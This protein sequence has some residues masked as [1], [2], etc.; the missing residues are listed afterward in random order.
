MAS[1]RP[2][3]AKKSAGSC[4]Q[5][6]RRRGVE[7]RANI[8]ATVKKAVHAR[9]R[10]H[11][12]AKRP[13]GLVLAIPRQSQKSACRDSLDGSLTVPFERNSTLWGIVLDGHGH[14]RIEEQ[15]NTCPGRSKM[16]P[17]SVTM[18]RRPTGVIC[19]AMF[20]GLWTLCTTSRC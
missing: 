9:G 20:G 13:R 16:T 2:L 18:P 7:P 17:I 4:A 19:C 14:M 1:E 11:E 6:I 5:D 3:A 8:F 15:V 12:P 10:E